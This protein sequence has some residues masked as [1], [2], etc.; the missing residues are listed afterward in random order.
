MRGLGKVNGNIVVV[1]ATGN[2]VANEILGDFP[3]FASAVGS[4]IITPT[5]VI[6]TDSAKSIANGQLNNNVSVVASLGAETE[7]DA[8]FDFDIFIGVDNSS[9]LDE[10]DGYEVL[11]NN[12][13][14]LAF[15]N[16]A[17]NRIGKDTKG[18]NDSGLISNLQRNE[19]GTSIQAS[20]DSVGIGVLQ[21]GGVGSADSQVFNNS[22]F[23][24]AV[25]NNNVNSIGGD[26]LGAE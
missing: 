1:A 17:S 22:I 16:N 12:A 26:G 25:G 10:I 2:S 23:S 24:Q 8:P 18:N 5:S 20:I 7:D 15:G 13:Q 3:A 4:S 19:N 9:P 6:N 11:N 21:N 14:S